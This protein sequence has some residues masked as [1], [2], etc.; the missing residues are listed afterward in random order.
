ML[1]VNLVTVYETID[2]DGYKNWTEGYYLT[3][4]PGTYTYAGTKDHKAVEIE[5]QY[6]LLSPIEVHKDTTDAIRAKALKKLSSAE[7]KAL[8][9]K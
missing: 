9:L 4:V 3:P 5:G 6:Y 1:K 2:S 7:K 8:G